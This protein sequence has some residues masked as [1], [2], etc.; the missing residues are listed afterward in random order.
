MRRI[1][2]APKDL[3]LMVNRKTT[4]CKNFSLP[5]IKHFTESNKNNYNNINKIKLSQLK[6]TKY[7][8]NTFN[9]VIGDMLNYLNINN[10]DNLI[11]S[12]T[13]GFL[14]ENFYNNN[15]SK[16]I[17]EFFIQALFRYFITFLI[18]QTILYQHIIIPE[19]NRVAI[20]F[21]LIN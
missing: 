7:I 21:H 1:K 18:H 14:S 8:A 13:V 20:I 5:N 9:N 11:I 15:K 3:A 17:Y 16:L 12:L 10:D 4:S 19:I 2:S 6:K